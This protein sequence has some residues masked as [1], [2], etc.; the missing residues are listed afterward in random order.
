MSQS[1]PVATPGAARRRHRAGGQDPRHRP[2]RRHRLGEGSSNQGDFHE[3]LNFAGIHKLPVDLRGREQR[4]RDQRPGQPRERRQGHRRRERAATACPAS[5]S[6]AP[7][8]WAATALV[9][10]PSHA[11]ARGRWPDAHRG[12]GH[13]ADGPLVGRPADQVPQRRGPRGGHAP[14]PAAPL[15]RRAARRQACSTTRSR[16]GCADDIKAVVEDARPNRPTARPSARPA[17]DGA[18]ATLWSTSSREG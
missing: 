13:A 17:A 12:Q 18:M 16:R 5:S 8:C 4:L 7:T 3:G 14:R 6:T 1:S 15:P 11:R 10:R 9:A 2:G